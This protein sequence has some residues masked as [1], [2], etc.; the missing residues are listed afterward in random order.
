MSPL[1][2]REAG[3]S[4]IGVSTARSCGTVGNYFHSA[5]TNFL[6]RLAAVSFTTDFSRADGDAARG[7][8]L[9]LCF[10]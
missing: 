4:E 7:A 3:E 1:P 9:Q 5:R 8:P 2:T 10:R 6:H